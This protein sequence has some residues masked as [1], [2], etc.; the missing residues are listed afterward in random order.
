MLAAPAIMMNMINITN[1]RPTWSK[2]CRKLV[3][4]LA[5]FASVRTKISENCVFDTIVC[6]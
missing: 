2:M 3:N 4:A 1:N 6:I 5:L